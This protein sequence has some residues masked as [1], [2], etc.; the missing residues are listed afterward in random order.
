M[1]L[2]GPTKIQ[3]SYFKGKI[4]EEEKILFITIAEK[5]TTTITNIFETI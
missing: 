4:S 2:E 5:N 1:I 3:N